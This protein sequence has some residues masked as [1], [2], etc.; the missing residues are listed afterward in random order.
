MANPALPRQAH[1]ASRAAMARQSMSSQKDFFAHTHLI[2]MGHAHGIKA[3][4]EL[5]QGTM[6]QGHWRRSSCQRT[7]GSSPA[8]Q[9]PFLFE[10]VLRTAP[11]DHQNPVSFPVSINDADPSTPAMRPAATIHLSGGVCI[12]IALSKCHPSQVLS[13]DA[14]LSAR[15][16]RIGAG[17]RRIWTRRD[18]PGSRSR[19]P[20]S[21]SAQCHRTTEWPPLARSTSSRGIPA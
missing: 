17:A 11:I 8:A 1:R 5:G 13:L 2:P 4:Q 18:D 16:A 3:M 15:L 20:R 12:G 14:R 7:H 21:P 9:S 10:T 6:P 19:R